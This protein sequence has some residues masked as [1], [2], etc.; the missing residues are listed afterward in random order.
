[1]K[2]F[3]IKVFIFVL[4]VFLLPANYLLLEMT[5]ERSGDL[6]RVGHL[7]FEKGYHS[8]LTPAYEEHFVIN[9]VFDSLPDS[10]YILSFGDSFSNL[11]FCTQRW[12]EYT[13]AALGKS[14]FNIH[15]LDNDPEGNVLT[16]LTYCSDSNLPELIIL[17]S[18]ERETICRLKNL[19]FNNPHSL[20]SISLF[21]D[22]FIG[23]EQSFYFKTKE[24]YQRRLGQNV[25]LV[26]SNLNKDVFSSKNTEKKL[27]CYYDDTIHYSVSDIKL[28]TKNLKRLYD[29]AKIRG[30]QLVY[31]ICPNKSNV[32]W[33]YI[34]EKD[35]EKY[36][37]ILERTNTFDTLPYV[38]NPLNLL[39]Q[40]DASGEKDIFYC[41]DSHWTPKTAKIVGTALAEYIKTK[42]KEQV[43]I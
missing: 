8:K 33:P 7:F 17:E 32:Y 14:I 12:N 13:G 15:S 37:N 38:F 21:P 24:Y 30:V 43:G 19:D 27:I 42:K 22:N 39:R 10:S 6:G 23:T 3:I 20:K 28:A 11:V 40:L 16:F 2:R 1:M 25:H 26:F 4:P 31:F 41:D 36:F 34:N 18:V 5:R 9:T 29:L 35:K